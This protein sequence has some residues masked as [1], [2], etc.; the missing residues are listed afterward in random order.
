[1]VTL[2]SGFPGLPLQQEQS[3][4]P[5]LAKKYYATAEPS[6]KFHRECT[7]SWLLQERNKRPVAHNPLTRKD[8]P[9]ERGKFPTGSHAA[10]S[11]LAKQTGLETCVS[12]LLLKQI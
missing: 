4:G 5:Y 2:E 7:D 8:T 11:K 6:F 3:I 10:L 1:M 9:A 12:G